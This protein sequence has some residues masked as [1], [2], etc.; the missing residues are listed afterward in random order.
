MASN[1]MVSFASSV[2]TLNTFVSGTP[3]VAT[4]VND[5]FTDVADSVN[6]NNSRIGVNETDIAD[7]TAAIAGLGGS[8]TCPSDM[9]PVGSSSLCVD[10]YEASV[11]DD[12]TG[13]S[14]LPAGPIALCLADG[15]NCGANAVG[16]AIYARSVAGVLPN[17]SVSWHQAVHACANV[18]KRLPTTAEW[19]A[20]AAGTPS[21]TGTGTDTNCN[22]QNLSVL[23]NTGVA[24]SC[25]S[26]AGAFD[27]VG[28]LMEWSA[29]L[30]VGVAGGW[31]DID[32]TQTARA[33]GESRGNLSTLTPSTSLSFVPPGGADTTNATIGFRCVK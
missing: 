31:S 1:S 2:P 11:Y 12:P 18:G 22:S 26:T 24:T 29:D 16:T 7:N 4:E 10:I 21:G 20:A 6:D 17:D 30:D 5:N 23:V 33:L 15:S 25:V 13:G 9:E 32:A 8:P 3:A 27:M 19:Q 14:K 28:N